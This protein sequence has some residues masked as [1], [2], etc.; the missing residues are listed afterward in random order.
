MRDFQEGDQVAFWEPTDRGIFLSKGWTITGIYPTGVVLMR[1]PKVMGGGD[2]KFWN[3]EGLAKTMVLV[4]RKEI[5]GADSVRGK[6][7]TKAENRAKLMREIRET[8]GDQK[9]DLLEYNFL[10]DQG[11]VV[12]LLRTPRLYRE[13]VP[14]GSPKYLYETRVLDL[15]TREEVARNNWNKTKAYEHYRNLI[16]Q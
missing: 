10:E 16:Q 14:S 9:V 4:K 12:E 5:E 6:T 7:Y 3:G 2:I 1:N 15:S 8:Y 11:V 13:G